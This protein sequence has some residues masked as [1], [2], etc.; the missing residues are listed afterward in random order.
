[1]CSQKCARPCTSVG[2]CSCPADTETAAAAISI[3]GSDTRMTSSLLG[4]S[5]S[6][7]SLVSESGLRLG[8]AMALL[9]LAGGTCFARS[10]SSALR[11]RR[12]RGCQRNAGAARS[13]AQAICRARARAAETRGRA[14]RASGRRGGGTEATLWPS[15]HT[16]C[17]E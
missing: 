3:V 8:T 5:T 12:R 17:V 16:M 15:Q 4:S 11:V 14:Q 1:M 7:Y 10:A 2:S 13:S 6:R 9:A